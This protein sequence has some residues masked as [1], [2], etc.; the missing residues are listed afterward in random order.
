MSGI[1]QIA[2]IIAMWAQK[3]AA[4]ESVDLFGS[5]VRGDARIDSDLDMLLRFDMSADGMSE[6][7]LFEETVPQAREELRHLV[8]RLTVRPLSIHEEPD[9]KAFQYV[10]RGEIVGHCG[11]VR[12][13]RTSPKLKRQ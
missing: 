10:E 3:Y 7:G 12:L 13:V 9:D 1:C 5:V 11:K 8:A 6:R 2:T 4:I